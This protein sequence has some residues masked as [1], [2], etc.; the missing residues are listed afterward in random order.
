[1][2]RIFWGIVVALVLLATPGVRQWLA[3]YVQPALDPVYE[4]TARS[5]V[6]EISRF[7]QTR[8]ATG[9]QLPAPKGFAGFLD[10]QSGKDASLDPWGSPYY[11]KRERTALSVGSAG[12]DRQPGTADDILAPVTVPRTRR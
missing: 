6:Q 12:R 2:G 11:L 5:R 7:L 4:W 10:D 8:A 9:K 1:M 3:P